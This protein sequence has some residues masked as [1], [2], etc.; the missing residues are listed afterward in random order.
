MKSS[1]LPSARYCSLLRIGGRNVEI[2]AR[3]FLCVDSNILAIDG[4]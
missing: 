2:D 3:G 1:S 4:V